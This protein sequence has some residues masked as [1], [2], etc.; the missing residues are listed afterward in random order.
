MKM[1]FLC[2]D[3]KLIGIEVLMVSS[4]IPCLILCSPWHVPFPPGDPCPLDLVWT[5]S[6]TGYRRPRMWV[7]KRASEELWGQQVGREQEVR[8]LEDPSGCSEDLQDRCPE[9]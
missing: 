5:H 1:C 3:R 8:G 2:L 6:S 4:H 9:P 7:R